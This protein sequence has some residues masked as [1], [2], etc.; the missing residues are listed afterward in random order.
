M[1]LD[2]LLPP[3]RHIQPLQKSILLQISLKGLCQV[4]Q[5]LILSAIDPRA[6][7]SIMGSSRK[8]LW[9]AWYV[10]SADRRLR[11]LSVRR[12]EKF[13][14]YWFRDIQ[15]P[16][17][18]MLPLFYNSLNRIKFLDLQSCTQNSSFKTKKR[19]FLELF[20]IFIRRLSRPDSSS[21]LVD[22]LIY[23]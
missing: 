23:E 14:R 5:I 20:F 7:R 12:R 21:I 11:F 10:V 13:L 6:V 15:P 3:D 17:Y 9:G 22:R 4:K 2:G 18:K 16:G 1:H 19:Q 8:G